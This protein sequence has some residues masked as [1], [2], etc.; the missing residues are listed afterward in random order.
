MIANNIHSFILECAPLFTFTSKPI[1]DEICM[2][3]GKSL[4]R[5]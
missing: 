4:E 1:T 3:D 5:R 2:K